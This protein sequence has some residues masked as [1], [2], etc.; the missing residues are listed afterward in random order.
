MPTTTF[1]IL[2]MPDSAQPKYSPE[3]WHGRADLPSSGVFTY[4]FS[5]RT[6]EIV[7]EIQLN[8]KLVR[9]S[10][11]DNTY[12]ETKSRCKFHKIPSE[13]EILNHL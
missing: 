9:A 8:P 11:M 6:D 10:I 13:T 3:T 5:D 2:C 12:K 4:S 7:I 1:E